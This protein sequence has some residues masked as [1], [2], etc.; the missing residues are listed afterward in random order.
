MTG[1][2]NLTVVTAAALFGV[3]CLLV[4]AWR[5]EQSKPPCFF[6]PGKGITL[7]GLMVWSEALSVE[8]IHRLW[9]WM[10]GTGERPTDLLA[11]G[12]G[13]LEPFPPTQKPF[14]PIQFGDAE[15]R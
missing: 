14:P 11:R 10:E 9:R 15:G 4:K 5:R 7:Y 2:L 1:L 6:A 13:N 12:R 8:D 3:F